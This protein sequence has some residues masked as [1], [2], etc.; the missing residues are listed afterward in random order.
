MPDWQQWKQALEEVREH[1][2]ARKYSS[3]I[4]NRSDHLDAV[5][6][7]KGQKKPERREK[8]P[9]QLTEENTQKADAEEFAEAAAKK[10]A[11]GS[12]KRGRKDQQKLTDQAE[13]LMGRLAEMLKKNSMKTI[14]SA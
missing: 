14:R 7:A 12:C 6:G 9:C 1:G 11:K 13:D 2:Q 4:H 10:Q 8:A 5:Q 3:K